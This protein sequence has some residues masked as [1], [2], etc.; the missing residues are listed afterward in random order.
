VSKRIFRSPPPPRSPDTD[1]FVRSLVFSSRAASSCDRFCS[2]ASIQV[3]CFRIQLLQSFVRLV[4]FQA[5]CPPSAGKTEARRSQ[6]WHEV[7]RM[8]CVPMIEIAFSQK[9]TK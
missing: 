9:H 3:N 2:L 6:I 1:L 5:V 7:V 4:P 8:V